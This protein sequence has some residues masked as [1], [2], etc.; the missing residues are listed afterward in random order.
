[1]LTI[2]AHVRIARDA[3]G[4]MVLDLFEGQVY[5]VNLVGSR[6]LEMLKEGADET[7]IASHIAREF[8]IEQAIA[9]ADLRE[10]LESIEKH[11][12]TSRNTRSLA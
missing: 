7:R 4:A 9:E 12:L 10:F 3:D 11:R 1:M 6:I 5:Q 2:P 8:E